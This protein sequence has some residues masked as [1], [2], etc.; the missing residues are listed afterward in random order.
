M[1]PSP[2]KLPSAAPPLGLTSLFDTRDNA[3]T[4]CAQKGVTNSIIMKKFWRSSNK[5]AQSV[6]PSMYYRASAQQA[7]ESFEPPVNAGAQEY[8]ELPGPVDHLA[9]VSPRSDLGFARAMAPPGRYQGEV[10]SASN[11]SAGE[12]NDL[13]SALG[14]SAVAFDMVDAESLEEKG[15]GSGG[16]GSEIMKTKVVGPS[17]L[18]EE[19]IHQSSGQ[20]LF[21]H[22]VDVPLSA[23]LS[24]PF[25]LPGPSF[26]STGLRNKVEPPATSYPKTWISQP[27]QPSQPDPM[28]TQRQPPKPDTESPQPTFR[29]LAPRDQAEIASKNQ[30]SKKSSTKKS[31]CCF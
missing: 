16:G 8:Y 29:V 13:S 3:I 23:T 7:Y 10:V 9:V 30:K 20:Q 12:E 19:E 4:Q 18:S 2:P 6:A 21:I 22:S 25:S 1:T 28:P 15:E 5:Q 11:F 17:L 31:L 26:P 14:F 24:R 27:D